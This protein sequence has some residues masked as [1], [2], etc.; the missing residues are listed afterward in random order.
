MADRNEQV[1]LTDALLKAFDKVVEQRQIESKSTSVIEGTIENIIN[2]SQG[3]YKIKYLNNYFEASASNK[4]Y[5]YNI[6]DRVYIIVPDGDMEKTKIILAPIATKNVRIENVTQDNLYIPYGDNLLFLNFTEESPCGLCS[7]RDDPLVRDEDGK[8]IGGGDPRYFTLSRPEILEAFQTSLK[9]TKTYDLN[10]FIKTNIASNRRINGNYGLYLNIPVIQ[11]NIEKDYEITLDIH[12]MIGFPYNFSTYAEQH[13]YFTIPDNTDININKTITLK[14]F[15]Q[16]FPKDENGTV[17]HED[18]VWISNIS[19]TPIKVLN[20]ENKEGYFL[21]LT[22]SQGA[23]FAN[24]VST[25]SQE[26]DLIPN[27]YY[28]GKETDL[29]GE[30]YKCYWFIQDASV[31]TNSLGKYHTYGGVGWRI[32]NDLNTTID[33]SETE[34]YKTDIFKYHIKREQIHYEVQYKCVIIVNNESIISDTILIKN[35]ATKVSLNISS[36]AK[37]NIY[38]ENTG[39]VK[40]IM[41][42]YETDITDQEWPDIDEYG[43]I[44]YSYRFNWQRYDRVGNL[45]PGFLFSAEDRKK[46][47]GSY[48]QEINFNTQIIDKLNTFVCTVTLIKTTKGE[49]IDDPDSTEDPPAKIR[50]LII[51]EF[52]IGTRTISIQTTAEATFGVKLENGRPFYKYDAWGNSPLVGNYDGAAS[53]RLTLIKPI[54]IAE[55]TH[56]DGNPFTEEDLKTLNVT[57][58]VPKDN[59]MI[60]ITTNST[61]TEKEINNKIYYSKTD[62][63][64]NFKNFNYTIKDVFNK[65]FVNNTIILQINLKNYTITEYI[66]ITFT[67][68]GESGTNGSCYS[69]VITYL[70][71][72][73]GE[74]DAETGLPHKCQLVFIANQP[75][76]WFIYNPAWVRST[77]AASPV[78]NR[79]GLVL[80]SNTTDEVNL[81]IVTYT[82][83]E[84]V[85]PKTQYIAVK[86]TRTMS[87]NY[88]MKF[89]VDL[90]CDGELVTGYG[91]TL[92]KEG[93]WEIFDDRFDYESIISPLEISTTNL[94]QGIINIKKTDNLGKP[95]DW[96]KMWLNQDGELAEGKNANNICATLQVKC[97]AKKQTINET[98]ND[99]T[100]VTNS[101]FYVYAYYPIEV[102]YISDSSIIYNYIPTLQGGFS[103]VIYTSSG[104]FPQY[105]N[106]TDF[107]IKGIEGLNEIGEDILQTYVD[108]QFICEYNW[109]YSSN[110]G[111]EK[112][113]KYNNKIKVIPATK[114]ENEISKNYLKVQVKFNDYYKDKITNL[115]KNSSQEIMTKII[116]VAQYNTIENNKDI[117]N[118]FDEG[119]NNPFSY[120]VTKISQNLNLLQSCED[121][122]NKVKLINKEIYK[123]VDLFNKYSSDAIRYPQEYQDAYHNILESLVGYLTSSTKESQLIDSIKTSPNSNI[124][125]LLNN[126]K[127]L[128]KVD[129]EVRPAEERYIPTEEELSYLD[130]LFNY[131]D[132]ANYYLDTLKEAVYKYISFV[133]NSQYSTL[134]NNLINNS[135]TFDNM[136]TVLDDIRQ[137]LKDYLYDPKWGHLISLISLDPDLDSRKNSFSTLY[138]TLRGYYLQIRLDKDLSNPF[139]IINDYLMKMKETLIPFKNYQID[140]EIEERNNL[141]KNEVELQKKL[142]DILNLMNENRQIIHI[143]PII[144]LYNCY[145]LGFL[146]GWDGNKLEID[147]DGGY[148]IAPQMGAG[149][150][151]DDN[152]FTGM[153]MGIYKKGNTDV[154][155]YGL[156]GKKRGVETLFLDCQT[157]GAVFGKSG[158]GQIYIDPE[159]GGQ[160]Y[161]GN[162]FGGHD[163][164][165]GKPDL[166]SVTGQGMLINLKDSY[167]HLGSSNG[168]IY[169]GQHI[170]SSAISDPSADPHDTEEDGFLLDGNGLSIGRG[171][172]IKRDGTTILGFE[173]DDKKYIKFDPNDK[174]FEIGEGVQLTATSISTD[175][176]T[177]AKM[178]VADGGWIKTQ[179]EDVII[180][181]YGITINNGV[182]HIKQGDINLGYGNFVVSSSGHLTANS[183]NI[184][185]KLTA[186]LNSWIGNWRV[187]DN[188]RLYG[189]EE[190]GKEDVDQIRLDPIA[191]TIAFFTGTIASDGN[192]D[193][194]YMGRV[195]GDNNAIG[196][197][198]HLNKKDQGGS[199]KADI[200]CGSISSK[201]IYC[202]NIH[203]EGKKIYLSSDVRIQSSGVYKHVNTGTNKEPKWEWKQVVSFAYN[204]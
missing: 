200:Y 192:R 103:D 119:E 74:A 87:D 153:V 144:M 121:L 175:A 146:N 62:S 28:N 72:A 27:L 137:K 56:T 201:D 197:Y 66:P 48:E 113:A 169:S 182:I 124:Q 156:F 186:G 154:E 108:N 1:Q 32:L 17:M 53:S 116:T 92:S 25:L 4:D 55:V 37:D 80:I 68:D 65:N 128:Q 185:G 51:E 195:S 71:K 44:Q 86:S 165:S 126:I 196:F 19:L 85:Q 168:F 59:S 202:G 183:V 24:N 31:D 18:D 173:D 158:S 9:Y 47:D 107:E 127:N 29:T 76:P 149:F 203:C 43:N 114:L 23:F 83:E 176:L 166:S 155:R 11:D 157:G 91:D 89:D 151:E 61:W 174:I 64:D 187:A 38:L 162:Y 15:I 131:R 109:G 50:D 14:A 13:C 135:S 90:Y 170:N 198:S 2:Q 122:Q 189:S 136:S 49:E 179:N 81:P 161:S 16:D 97:R 178:I 6:G 22:A 102:T 171:V 88:Y 42:Y 35:L 177:G 160:I 60:K 36:S 98:L 34:T 167:I 164:I 193:F 163:N 12:N 194:A 21:K 134:F 191:G 125:R 5:I 20:A 101:P 33:A 100:S 99:S 141:I 138:N 105:D 78:G 8:V 132:G 139:T 70:D 130:L 110:L 143:K 115:I 73:Y 180:D 82:V 10:C 159:I 77:D 181:E 84:E 106:S 39:K 58:N 93:G 152:S 190:Y 204:A 40:L 133:E 145:E 67:K 30:E 150:K 75:E 117:F 26:K 148:I 94:V 41:N 96:Y 172:R 120:V 188:G 7:F 63:F 52:I 184:S 118:S 112:E 199:G 3:I 69:A 147:K 54:T 104:L 123:V 57:W 129:G 140:K 111:P 142:M 45:Q 79:L 95:I 46:E